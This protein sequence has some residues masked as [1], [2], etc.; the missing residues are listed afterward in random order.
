MA[1]SISSA[2][3]RLV[4]TL[5]GTVTI[6][7]AQN[8]AASLGES[9]EEDMPLRVETA[10]LEDVDTSILQLLCSVR[11]TSRAVTFA[12]PGEIFL[13]AMDRCGLR[14]ELLGGREEP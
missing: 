9:L 8:L 5:E 10:G 1:Y 6:R 2:S 11:K 4:L 12:E 14:R 7:H 3:G 13:R